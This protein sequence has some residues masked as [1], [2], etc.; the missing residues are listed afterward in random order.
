MGFSFLA[1]SSVESDVIKGLGKTG[2]GQYGNLISL[3][4]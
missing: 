2:Q 3:I 1:F 4:K